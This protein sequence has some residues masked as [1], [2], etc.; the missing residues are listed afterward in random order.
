MIDQSIEWVCIKLSLSFCVLILSGRWIRWKVVLAFSVP[1]IKGRKILCHFSIRERSSSSLP[2][3]KRMYE[4][5]FQAF[6][7]LRFSLPTWLRL[8]LPVPMRLVTER[9]AIIAVS[10]R[11]VS[12]CS[13]SQR[14]LAVWCPMEVFTIIYRMDIWSHGRTKGILSACCRRELYAMTLA[15]C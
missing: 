4:K 1:S 12:F 5:V 10:C 11:L 7:R 2:S 13:G 14:P 15:H 8:S 6:S 3:F 9:Q